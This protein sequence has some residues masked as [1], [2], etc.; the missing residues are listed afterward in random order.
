MK[1]FFVTALLLLATGLAAQEHFTIA[2]PDG[3]LEAKITIGKTI[4][5]S[6]HH[7]GYLMLAPSPLSLTLADGHVWG[8]RSKLAGSATK[9]V[10]DSIKA[11]IYKR[12][13]VRDRYN[14]LTLSFT[15]PFRVIFRLYDEGLAYRFVPGTNKPLTVKDEQVEYHLPADQKAYI[16]Y[17]MLQ[18]GSLDEQYFTSFENQYQHIPVSAWDVNRLAFT[19]LLVE[20]ANGKKI[21]ITEAD[22]LDYPGMFL[23]NGDGGTVIKARFAPVP[24]E[25]E[26]GG[27]N[28]L[29]GIVKSRQPYIATFRG[30]AT[31]P[32]RVLVVSS[33]D[34]EL[35]D[36]DLVYKLATPPP[37][38]YID[39]SWIKP[40]KVAWEWWNDWGVYGGE[41]KAGINTETYEFYIDFA[42]TYG[43]DYVILDEGWAVNK[44]A[45]LMQVVPEIDL[46]RLVKYAARRDV[47]I[48][49]W[50]GYWALDKD[51]DGIFA[52]YAAMGVKGFK[53]DFMDRDDQQVVDFHRRVAEAGAK[54]HLLVDFHGTYK[55]TG[56]QRTY[57][58][59]INF[60]GVFGLEQMKW[61]SR[62]VDQVT[63]DVTF[64]F[65]RMIAGPVDYTQGAIRNAARRAYFPS[66]SE[67]MSQGTRCHQLAEYVI[68]ESPLSMLCDSP[69]NY[70][71]DEE[72]TRFIADVPTV[73]SNTIALDGEVGQ[74]ISIARSSGNRWYVGALNNWRA[75]TVE[76]DL[77]FLGEG[78]FRADCFQDGVNAGRSGRDYKTYSATIPAD[79][80]FFA[81]LAP[82]GGFVMRIYP[83]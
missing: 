44:Q 8:V 63:Y 53:V 50:A 40:G 77:S 79:R 82:G 14:E 74:Y 35:A 65:I 32:W 48:I 58:N 31:L 46:P 59:V 45:D 34:S 83:E 76:L 6:V 10:N 47:G 57:P 43:I 21:C 55:P 70:M 78:N 4:E 24:R 69:C 28:Q 25:V 75:R 33:R 20:G 61:A 19:P 17:V 67:P 27:H 56:L 71:L 41:F 30:Q 15:D 11:Y 39:D 2:S 80:K 29:Q 1:T 66:Y 13:T 23:Y 73:W 7:D 18:R 5:Y 51:V 38:K 81:P 3:R 37:T 42:T 60:E 52:H 9:S 26:Q 68:F 16:P 64:P 49:L 62:E 12:S 36:N 22:L 54:H 72:T